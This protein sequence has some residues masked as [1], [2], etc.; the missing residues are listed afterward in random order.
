MFQT[1]VWMACWRQQVRMSE[2]TILTQ[3]LIGL[4]RVNTAFGLLKV[5]IWIRDNTKVS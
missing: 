3:K 5:E 2:D 4:W 1:E